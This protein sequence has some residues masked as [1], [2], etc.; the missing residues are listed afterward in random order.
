MPILSDTQPAPIQ[1]PQPGAAT[2][3]DERRY[4]QRFNRSQAR[5]LVVQSWRTATGDLVTRVGLERWLGL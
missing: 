4:L 2:L 3:V 1:V 5:L